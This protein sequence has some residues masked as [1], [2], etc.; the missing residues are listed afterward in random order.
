M[1]LQTV[2]KSDPVFRTLLDGTFSDTHR[3]IPLRTI[4]QHVSF[5]LA[6]FEITPLSKIEK[7]RFLTLIF[8]LL[9]PQHFL[10]VLIPLLYTFFSLPKE[11]ANF[12]IHKN[13]MILLLISLFNLTLFFNLQRTLNE[14]FNLSHLYSSATTSSILQR[15]WLKGITVTR[16]SWIFLTITTLAALPLI[17]EQP[18]ALSPIVLLTIVLFAGMNLQKEGILYLITS[19]FNHFILAGPLIVLGTCI[20][21]NTKP[22]LAQWSFAASWGLWILLWRQLRSFRELMSYSLSKSS[23][24][25]AQMGFDKTLNLLQK[26]II[27]VPMICLSLLALM[28]MSWVWLLTNATLHSYFIIKEMECLNKTQSSISSHLE[29]LAI[30]AQKHHY[31]LALTMITLSLFTHHK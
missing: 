6:T 12:L 11:N 4:N 9:K 7:P 26:L 31:Y 14:H 15:G 3:A 17:L 29:D 8:E 18:M 27:T 2:K 1:E 25:V 22:T 23:R 19:A 5:N 21:F 13:K 30:I 20:V 24:F 16:L 28:P 10:I